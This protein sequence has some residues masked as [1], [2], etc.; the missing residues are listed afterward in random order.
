MGGY[1]E[2]SYAIGLFT[3]VVHYT[4]PGIPSMEEHKPSQAKRAYYQFA[5]ASPCKMDKGLQTDKDHL[6]CSKTSAK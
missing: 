2:S 6:Q 5:E 3:L 1:R 4:E